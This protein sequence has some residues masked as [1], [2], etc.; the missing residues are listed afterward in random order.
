MSLRSCRFWASVA[1]FAVSLLLALT[2][3]QTAHAAGLVWYAQC[4]AGN[5]WFNAGMVRSTSGYAWRTDNYMRRRVQP[6]SGCGLSWD[7]WP[8]G[9]YS[10]KPNDSTHYRVVDV[11]NYYAYISGYRNYY[12]SLCWN[13][14]VSGTIWGDCN[15]YTE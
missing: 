8:I 11:V 2:A 10:L 4:T 6:A 3:S 9:L 12:K 1:T 13:R 15:T 5:G 7:T 14:A